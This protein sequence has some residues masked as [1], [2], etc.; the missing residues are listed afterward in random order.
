MPTSVEQPAGSLSPRRRQAILVVVGLALMMVV[1]AVSGLNVAL[2]SLARDTGATQSE[3]QW[4]VDAYTVVFAGLLLVAGAIGDRYGRRVILLVGLGLFGGAAAVALG[5]DEP[6]VLI[7]LRAV[8][9][10]G[11]AAV[12]PVTLSIITTSFPPEE[13][14]RAV[15]VWVGITG[16]GAVIGLLG[17]GVLLEFFGWSSFFALNVALAVA[18]FVGALAVIPASREARPPAL[19][20]LGALLSLVS[21]STIV[22]GFIEGPERGWDDGLTV[23]AFVVGVAAVIGFVLWELCTPEP[24]LDPR[25]FRLR[26]F[27]TGSL[28]LTVQFFA[29][30][31]LFYTALQY[32]QFVAGLSPL[33]AAAALLPLPAVLIPLARRA[34]VLA[35]RYGVNRI[36]AAGLVLVA[37]GLVVLSTVGVDFA[38]WRFGLG[39]VI[40]AAGMGLTATPATTAIVSSLA[41]SKQGVASAVNDTARELG[42]A[43][44]IAILGSI[45]NATYR[46]GLEPA[47]GSLP[48]GVAAGALGSIAFVQ[49]GVVEQLGPA[50]DP[51]V[52]AARQ[53]FVDGVSAALLWASVIV[54]VASVIVAVR[55][56]RA[57][58]VEHH[59]VSAAIGDAVDPTGALRSGAVD[60]GPTPPAARRPIAG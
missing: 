17:S 6:G 1:S 35:E 5:V 2:P 31:G 46:N 57:G 32:L 8:M 4:I 59:A 42:S 53:A 15:G 16:G 22:F 56:P 55:A 9:G 18:A 14:A 36:G 33:Q 43:L 13:R 11:A 58:E 29:A 24:L 44:G 54:V 45:L 12:M 30:F 38:Y 23:S 50:G 21:I 26:G 40:F 51:L 25:L 34:P 20:V 60:R 7:A 19:D 41:A 39:L 49:S 3:I 27:G 28:A 37:V 48:D 47:V 52:A 10:V